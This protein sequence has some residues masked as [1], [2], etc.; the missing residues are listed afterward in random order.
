MSETVSLCVRVDLGFAVT[1]LTESRLRSLIITCLHSR[2]IDPML[3]MIFIT[4]I[5]ILSFVIYYLPLISFFFFFNDTATTEIYTLSLH[6]P[7]PFFFKEH[8]SQLHS[9]SNLACRLPL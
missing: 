7:L 9:L 3:A 6:Y 8:A 5:R 1:A 2:L 4:N